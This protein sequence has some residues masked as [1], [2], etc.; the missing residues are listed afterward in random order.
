MK[1]VQILAESSSVSADGRLSCRVCETVTAGLSVI[2]LHLMLVGKQI[3]LPDHDGEPCPVY[4]I[5]H[6]YPSGC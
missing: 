1:K 3:N 2:Y 5:L 4:G 6:I